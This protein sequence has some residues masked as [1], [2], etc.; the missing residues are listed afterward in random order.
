MKKLFIILNLALIALS[1]SAT[2][3]NTLLSHVSGSSKHVKSPAAAVVS[4]H[5]P[6]GFEEISR[7]YTKG[8]ISADSLVSLGLYHKAAN[9]ALAEQCLKLAASKGNPRAQMELG[10]LYVF[11]PEFASRSQEGLQLLEAAAKAGYEGANDYLG[12]YYFQKKDYTKAKAYFDSRKSS[13]YGFAHTA[14]GSMYLEGKGVRESG[15]MARESYRQGALQGYSRGMSLYANLLGTKNGGSL[16]YPDAFFWH[17]I[18]GDMG[19]NYSR[20][21]LYRPQIP[22]KTATGEVARDAQSALQW[23][24]KVHT[25]KSLKNE[26]IYKKGFLVGLKEREKAAENG[27]DWS[28]FYLGSMNYNGDFLN[29]N[30]ARAIYYYEPIAKNAKLPA[31]LLAIV[32][33]RLAQM[34]GQGKGTKADPVK[35]AEYAK[36]AAKYG[37]VSAYKAIE[38]NK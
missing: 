3:R 1:A 10:S 33:E 4:Q 27:D 38:Q 12:F 34:Y 5:S 18:A 20:V 22:Q 26:P 35:A 30:Y 28:R 9:P 31:S 6:A 13:H 24:E 17:Y 2:G 15:K 21:M 29:Q 8:N 23:I 36:K 14:L 32:N 37:N 7:Q 25:G 11:T 16:N 19:E